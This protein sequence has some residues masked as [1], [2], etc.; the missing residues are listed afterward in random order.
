MNCQLFDSKFRK[1]SLKKLQLVKKCVT[2]ALD[3]K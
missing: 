1:K 3:M 2:F